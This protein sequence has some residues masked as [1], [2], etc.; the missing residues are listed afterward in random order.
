[1]TRI[2]VM[3]L[4]PG[5]FVYVETTRFE[6]RTTIF[7]KALEHAFAEMLEGK[8]VEVSIDDGAMVMY[9]LRMV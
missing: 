3:R 5:R 8:A 9:C 4:N 2:M 1:M 6:S 7:A